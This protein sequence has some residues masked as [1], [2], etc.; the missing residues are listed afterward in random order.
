MFFFT[1]YT[2]GILFKHF[3]MKILFIFCNC[4][5]LLLENI[6]QKYM[7]KT[8]IKQNQKSLNFVYRLKTKSIFFPP[9]I[10]ISNKCKYLCILYSCFFSSQAYPSHSSLH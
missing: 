6:P 5:F 2:L 3:D 9:S 10:L 1:N 7:L 4:Y 8:H